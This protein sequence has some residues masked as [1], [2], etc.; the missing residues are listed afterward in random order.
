MFK[1]ILIANRSGAEAIHPGYGFLSERAHFAKAC[2]DAGLVFI[3]PSPSAI[4]AMGDKV[5]ARKRMI[6]AKVPVVP[7]SEG[8]L[9]S[10]EDV[11]ATAAKIGFPVMLKA[12]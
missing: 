12:A 4:D 9:D 11:V 3:G 6:A 1:K 5:E 10:E 7:G 8:T 2:G